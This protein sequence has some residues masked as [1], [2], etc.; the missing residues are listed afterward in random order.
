MLLEFE[1][2]S[3]IIDISV[4]ICN[5]IST[6]CGVLKLLIV[7]ECIEAFKFLEI[8]YK[9]SSLLAICINEI[10]SSTFNKF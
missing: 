1:R 8:Q 6:G 7:G 2:D 10:S 3:L 5:A 4:S 9:W